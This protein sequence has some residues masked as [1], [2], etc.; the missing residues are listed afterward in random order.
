MQDIKDATGINIADQLN[1]DIFSILNW[2]S[3]LKTKRAI[4]ET[5]MMIWRQKNLSKK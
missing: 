2:C 1:M 4:E 3:Y 5:Q